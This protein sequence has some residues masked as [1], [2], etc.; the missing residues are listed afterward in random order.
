MSERNDQVHSSGEIDGI[1]PIAEAFNK[2]QKETALDGGEPLKNGGKTREE[3]SPP[4]ISTEEPASNTDND[5]EK[6]QSAEE[7]AGKIRNLSKKDDKGAEKLFQEAVKLRYL[8]RDERGRAAAIDKTGEAILKANSDRVRGIRTKEKPQKP[9]KDKEPFQKPGER[10]EADKP[11]EVKNNNN[12]KSEREEIDEKLSQLRE[13]LQSA[14]DEGAE[15]MVLKEIDELKKRRAEL[16]EEE[17]DARTK[18]I[19]KAKEKQAADLTKKLLTPIE[20]NPRTKLMKAESS[21]NLVGIV[22]C[23]PTKEIID[24]VLREIESGRLYID[25]SGNID[26]HAFEVVNPLSD[27]EATTDLNTGVTVGE[28]KNTKGLE[29]IE[30]IKAKVIESLRNEIRKEEKDPAAIEK[31]AQEFMASEG[32][33]KAV[34]AKIG[35]LEKHQSPPKKGFLSRVYLLVMDRKIYDDYVKEQDSYKKSQK[36]FG[37]LRTLERGWFSHEQRFIAEAQRLEDKVLEL[38]PKLVD[39]KLGRK[40]WKEIERAANRLALNRLALNESLLS[41]I[42]D[43]VGYSGQ[44]PAF[45]EWEGISFGKEISGKGTGSE[46]FKSEQ[47]Q[48]RM[49]LEKIKIGKMFSKEFTGLSKEYQDLFLKEEGGGSLRNLSE[50]LVVRGE[51]IDS[52]NKMIERGDFNENPLRIYQMM[53]FLKGSELE[54][55]KREKAVSAAIRG[56]SFRESTLE[57]GRKTKEGILKAF[58]DTIAKVDPGFEI[59]YDTELKEIILN[60]HGKFARSISNIWEFKIAANFAANRTKWGLLG[61][62]KTFNEGF[63]KLIP[64]SKA[65]QKIAILSEQIADLDGKRGDLDEILSYVVTTRSD[66]GARLRMRNK[67]AEKRVI[68]RIINEITPTETRAKDLKEKYKSEGLSAEFVSD[69][70][71]FCQIQKLM[72]GQKRIRIQRELK[73]VELDSEYIEKNTG[74]IKARIIDEMSGELLDMQELESQ[75]LEAQLRIAERKLLDQEEALKRSVDEQIKQLRDKV[76]KGLYKKIRQVVA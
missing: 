70:V 9:I 15:K 62:R 36:D 64:E 35:E 10:V 53:N 1:N 20:G 4:P 12:K 41:K 18:E 57:L 29:F 76:E 49:L 56:Y 66:A 32:L 65:A 37:E 44:L 13:G 55:K 73:K 45:L 25:A 50:A 16:I 39:G 7:V 28:I 26:V 11:A 67:E 3:E 75:T 23:A 72:T 40:E 5:K 52:I 69:F 31:K 27:V 42:A 22:Q 61:L 33:G 43:K 51:V 14:G 6:K 8:R 34:Y 63:E 74:K 17:K 68:L 58:G 2:A 59:N 47:V 24:N 48:K 46:L 30:N 19:R 38:T 71:T 21:G 60:G 54:I